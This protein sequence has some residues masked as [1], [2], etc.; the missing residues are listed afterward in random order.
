MGSLR[1]KSSLRGKLMQIQSMRLSTMIANRR[2]MSGYKTENA[3]RPGFRVSMVGVGMSLAD[4]GAVS[5]CQEGFG[6]P[7]VLLKLEAKKLGLTY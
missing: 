4:T 7:L 2:S 5:H 1:S 6:R 3:S